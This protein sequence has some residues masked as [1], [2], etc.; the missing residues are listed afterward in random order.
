[1][2]FLTKHAGIWRSEVGKHEAGSADGA[3][4]VGDSG[5]RADAPLCPSF[6]LHPQ[7]CCLAHLQHSQ[8]AS[9]S[10]H[11]DLCVCVRQRER[12]IHVASGAKL[13]QVAE[14]PIT[15]VMNVT[16][17]CQEPHTTQ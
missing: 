14:D 13:S 17:D 6:T 15:V 2:L 10:T 12:A 16:T 1:M 5:R 3:V 8:P 9:C 4:C 11:S 7:L